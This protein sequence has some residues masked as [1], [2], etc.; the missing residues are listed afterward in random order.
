ME[1]VIK[2]GGKKYEVVETHKRINWTKALD[3]KLG[4]LK[5]HSTHELAKVFG[6]DEQVILRRLKV[7]NLTEPP[8]WTP[9]LDEILRKF[10]IEKTNQELANMVGC[11]GSHVADRLT[12]LK[13][14]RPRRDR[15]MPKGGG[16]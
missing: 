15:K 9:K 4:R 14:R 5:D 7:L 2:V 13:L 1:K 12:Y 11:S 6:C 16:E 10:Y 8:F 3:T